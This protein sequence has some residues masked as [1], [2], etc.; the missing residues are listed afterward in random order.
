MLLP[1]LVQD[2]VDR[3]AERKD[4]QPSFLMPTVEVKTDSSHQDKKEQRMAKHPPVT[5]K[6]KPQG[7]INNVGK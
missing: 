1:H 3:S 7:L 4:E 6:Q 5:K 2:E